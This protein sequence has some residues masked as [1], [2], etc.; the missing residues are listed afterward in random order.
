MTLTGHTHNAG[1]MDSIVAAQPLQGEGDT[2]KHLAPA[3]GTTPTSLSDLKPIALEGMHHSATIRAAIHQ[4]APLAVVNAFLLPL[5]VFA[6]ADEP[7]VSLSCGCF[8]F[9]LSDVTEDNFDWYAAAAWAGP[10]A[11]RRH[12]IGRPL[13]RLDRRE[14]DL[15]FGG[16]DKLIYDQLSGHLGAESA[17]LVDSWRRTQGVAIEVVQSTWDGILNMAKILRETYVHHSGS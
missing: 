5:H 2:D 14:L 13:T 15:G 8:R 1:M 6:S 17:V 3:S 11:E 12:E 7:A 4:V 9:S 16:P 10:V